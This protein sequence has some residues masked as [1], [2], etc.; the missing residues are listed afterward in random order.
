MRAHKKLRR[1]FL[2]WD[3]LLVIFVLGL[4]FV[5]L[6]LMGFLWL[7]QHNAILWFLASC[8]L[9]SVGTVLLR[10]L[11]RQRW[12][13]DAEIGSEPG[14]ESTDMSVEPDPDWLPLE[15]AVFADVSQH[16]ATMTRSALPWEDLPGH[17]LEIVNKVAAGLDR[18]NPGV[19]N[20]S[21]LNFTLPEALLLLESTASR[22]REHLRNRLPFSDQ[23]SLATLYWL[24]RQRDR[25]TVIWQ[26]AQGGSRLARFALNPAAGILRE[27]EQIVSGG[28]SAYMTENMIG[29]M[30]AVLLEE[31]AYG[32][33]ELYSGRLRFSDRELMQIELATNK[34]DN[35]HKALPDA[36]VRILFVGQTSAGK[37]TLINAL[38]ASDLAE[39][40][41][42]ATTP[43]LVTYQTGFGGVPCNFLDSEGLD[44]STQ[45]LDSMLEEMKQADMIVWVVRINR[46]ARDM[47]VR[48]KQS[49]DAWFESHPR[50]RKPAVLVIA[51]ATDQLVGAQEQWSASAQTTIAAAVKVIADDLKVVQ[52]L[53]FSAGA[54]TWNLGIVAEALRAGLAE[55]QHVQR[56]RRRVEGASR[57]SGIRSQ[58]RRGG[59]GVRLGIRMAA[60]RASK[61]IANSKEN[62]KKS[63]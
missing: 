33:I 57:E 7:L 48:L 24:W 11:L 54:T 10:N 58:L 30:Q 62:R 36:P 8:L 45:S 42:A 19:K 26:V 56:N 21:A 5:L 3:H 9:V 28:N 55:A 61:A 12:R 22:Y 32:A 35:K 38:L 34:T 13:R 23:V 31:V 37:S 44:G 41:A 39:T 6:I 16:I 59:R 17:A 15:K 63:E 2:R 40:D 51:T 53:P 18:K 20:K 25:A 47:D 60:S 49:F 50:R 52:V 14:P 46:P 27:L 29:V 4:P 1:A 43:N